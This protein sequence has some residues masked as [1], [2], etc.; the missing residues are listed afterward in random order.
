MKIGLVYGG[1][2]KIRD[3]IGAEMKFEFCN[4]SNKSGRRTRYA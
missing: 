4:S 3:K 2:R 1:G